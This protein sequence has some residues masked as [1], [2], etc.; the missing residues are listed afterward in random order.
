MKRRYEL[1]FIDQGGAWFTE[2][3]QFDSRKRAL[4]AYRAEVLKMQLHRHKYPIRII[5]ILEGVNDA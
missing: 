3:E 4:V 5:E 1:Q 2:F